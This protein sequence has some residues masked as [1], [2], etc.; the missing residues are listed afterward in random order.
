MNMLQALAIVKD[1]IRIGKGMELDNGVPEA[2][3]TIVEG[4]EELQ[5]VNKLLENM[6]SKQNDKHKELE[7]DIDGALN[8]CEGMEQEL[9]LYKKALELAHNKLLRETAKYHFATPA[10][11]ESWL[12]IAKELAGDTHG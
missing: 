8:T 6:I 1:H 11:I 12:E 3:E 10:D 5:S 7:D 2:L 9:A 4:L